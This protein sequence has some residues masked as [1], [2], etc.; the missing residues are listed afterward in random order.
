MSDMQG[1][2]RAFF[3]PRHIPGVHFE[4]YLYMRAYNKFS[5]QATWNR[6]W[7]MLEGSKLY[8]VRD[9]HLL[10]GD[11]ANERNL[12]CDVVLSTVREVVTSDLPYCFE[13]F[14]ANRKSYLLQAEGPNDFQAWIQA[15]RYRRCRIE[16]TNAM[17]AVKLASRALCLTLG[18]AAWTGRKRIERLLIGDEPPA[19]PTT[20][21]QHSAS[22][23]LG[24]QDSPLRNLDGMPQLAAEESATSP[25]PT[26]KD[27]LLRELAE[28]NPTCV[29]CGSPNPDW[30]SINLGVFICIQCSG[31]HRSLGVHISKVSGRS[32]SVRAG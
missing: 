25:E 24:S 8:Y 15:I 7:F 4:S 11:E 30:V 16:I 10:E 14:S 19:P 32:G 12:V 20:T 31:I 17:R 26:I 5:G 6:K 3:R 9:T 29:D 28:Q 13:V 21:S 2:L 1:S 22:S 27:P 23:S 18:L